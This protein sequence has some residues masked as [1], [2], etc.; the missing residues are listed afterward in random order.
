[1]KRKLLEEIS[2]YFQEKPVACLT[3]NLILV[4]VAQTVL[5]LGFV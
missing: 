5:D 1:M 3:Q 4:E 2:K